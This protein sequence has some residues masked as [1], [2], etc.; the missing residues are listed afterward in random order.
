MSLRAVAEADNKAILED[1]D[2][3]FGYP[4]TIT[5][6]DGLVKPMT[7]F[8]NDIHFS[9]DPDTGTAVSVRTASVALNISSLIAAGFATLP[10]AIQ[11]ETLNPW[12]VQF[13]D[14]NGNPFTF[15]VQ[16]GNPDRGLGMITCTLEIWRDKPKCR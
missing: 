10:K 9:L 15:K 4:I 2:T 1:S 13:N 7:G 11:D 5:D 8:S 12:L 3:G 14:I 6:P 16:E